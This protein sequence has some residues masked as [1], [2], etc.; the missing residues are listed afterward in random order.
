M[1]S[2]VL[3]RINARVPLTLAPA[4][5]IAANAALSA[6]LI[7]S[8]AFAAA[9]IP[10]IWHDSLEACEYA[11]DAWIKRETGP[12]YCLSPVFDLSVPRHD[13][14][15]SDTVCDCEAVDICWFE[16]DICQWPVG[17]GL[18]RLNRLTNGLGVIVLHVLIRQSLP[19]YPLFTPDVARDTASFKGRHEKGRAAPDV[20]RDTA[21]MMYWNGEDDE[22][23]VLDMAF[24]EGDTAGREA[25]REEMVTSMLVK[26]A[27]PAWALDRPRSLD[28]PYCA[29]HLRHSLRTLIDPVARQIAE[30]ALALSQLRFE[31]DFS[32]ELDTDGEFIAFGGVLSWEQD[33]V[34]VRI[35]DDLVYMAHQGEFCDHIGEIHLEFSDPAALGKW[36][37][38][39][40]VQ[41]K[42]IGLIDRLIHD[43]SM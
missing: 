42:A 16:G 24:D 4:P 12:L 32:S 41:F 13:R 2:L 7:E 21:S 35:Y 6:F 43:L 36:Q 8:Q 30:N 25:M 11:L 18:E 5:R 39:M 38:D 1:T 9:D 22:E 28:L 14:F 15:T 34:T 10:S 3:P 40:R 31:H 20:A 23:V 26:S 27:S 19:V 29:R 33:D 17:A 37:R